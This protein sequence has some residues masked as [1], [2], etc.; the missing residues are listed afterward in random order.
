MSLREFVKNTIFTVNVR[1]AILISGIINSVIIARILGPE[2][3]GIYS[4]VVLLPTILLIFSDFGISSASVYYISKKKYF[5]SEVFGMNIIYS[6]LVGTILILVGLIITYF[7]NN[8]L[9][10]GIERKY[11]LIALLVIPIQIFFLLAINILLGLQKIKEYNL[12]ILINNYI[13]LVL[14]AIFLLKFHFGITAAIVTN[15]T[16]ILIASI[17]LYFFIKYHVGKATFTLNKK[18]V[19]DFFSY[20]I[21]IYIK[22]VLTFLQ[23]KLGIILLNIFLNPTAVGLYSVG[24]T[25][26]EK[27]QIISQSVNILIFPKISS[28]SNKKIVKEFTPLVCRNILFITFLIVLTLF[29][30]SKQIIIFLYSK[31]FL[32]SIVPFQILLIGIVSA[33]GNEIIFTDLMGRGKPFLITP[34][35]IFSIIL[36]LMLNILLIPR[37]GII[38]A[39]WSLVITYTLNFLIT[40]IIY[41][42][43]SGNKIN[44]IILIK[45]SDFLYY[46]KLLSF[47]IG[48]IQNFKVKIVMKNSSFRSL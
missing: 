28:E 15:I 45:K 48:K 43:I 19:K 14:I 20:G 11:L 40:L 8:K 36:N 5:P 7:F 25:I 13:F 34:V 38:G 30:V 12:I 37:L 18:R 42:R 41:I 23:S 4:L 2:G 3:N 47:V 22:T 31:Q 26:T 6:I 27:I 21:N 39:A 44:D 9:F 17:I 33:S 1:I 29:F 16:S 24:I 46:K 10:P 35:C 32:K